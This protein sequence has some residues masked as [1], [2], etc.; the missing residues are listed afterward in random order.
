MLIY[1]DDDNGVKWKHTPQESAVYRPPWQT[2]KP[3]YF[4]GQCDTCD[5]STGFN[6]KGHGSF[7]SCSLIYQG[8]EYFGKPDE[9]NSLRTCK[10]EFDC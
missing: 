8:R 4:F 1:D 5:K 3:V 10:V 9:T 7:Q 2:A 6:G